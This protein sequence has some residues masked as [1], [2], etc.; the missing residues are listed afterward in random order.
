MDPTG[1]ATKAADTTIMGIVHDA[2][3]RDQH[4]RSEDDGLWPVVR[5]RAANAETV[6]AQMD[7]VVVVA[8]L[9]HGKLHGEPFDVGAD[10]LKT[11]ADGGTALSDPEAHDLLTLAGLD[12]VATRRQS[13]RPRG[14]RL[15]A[16][17]PRVL[18]SP[19]GGPGAGAPR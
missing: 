12:R 6:F 16:S 5:S 14:L 11:L 2:L 9:G 3:R 19:G 18:P 4:H 8:V 10:R 15:M 1:A 7:E 17:R 13:G